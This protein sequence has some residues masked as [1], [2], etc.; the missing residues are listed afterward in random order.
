MT[1]SC[2]MKRRNCFNVYLKVAIGRYLVKPVLMVDLL[3]LL[4]CRRI[5]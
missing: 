1:I 3:Y 4:S 2:D 5:L